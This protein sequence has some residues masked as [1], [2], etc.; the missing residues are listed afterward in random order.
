[1]EKIQDPNAVT[2]LIEKTPSEVA[3]IAYCMMMNA[4]EGYPSAEFTPEAMAA[5]GNDGA[6]Q[7]YFVKS[8]EVHMTI[9]PK[10]MKL[11]RAYWALHTKEVKLYSC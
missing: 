4:I 2:Y 11:G 8:D 7:G 5:Y 9:T 1:M 6:H 10:G 3:R